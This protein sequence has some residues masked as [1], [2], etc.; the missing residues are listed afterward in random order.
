MSVLFVTALF[1]S[2]AEADIEVNTVTGRED[3]TA[4][5]AETRAELDG[6]AVLWN[7]TD[8]L[9]IFTNTA[10]NR[11]YGVKSLSNGN[12]SATFRYLGYSGSDASA[13]ENNYALYPYDANA[14]LSGE[15]ITTKINSEQIY[16]AEKVD[17]SNAL[18][19]AK[20]AST[21][22]QFVNST[23]L[24]RFYITNSMPDSYT[25]SSIKLVS[26]T[27][28]IA[29]EVTID[30]STD[31]KA[32]VT[33]N[34]VNEITLSGI[35]TP[36]T[37]QE[38]AFY[39]VIPATSFA[40]KDLTVTFTYAEGVEKSFALPAF[41]LELGSIKTIAYTINEGED[42]EG[43]TPETEL[44]PANNEIWY[45]STDGEIVKPY[46]GWYNN[47]ADALT[48][49][50]A[51]IVSNTY[52]DGKG[53][54]E[55][56]GDVT[57]IG[58]WAFDYCTS[59]TSV[60]IP[61]SVTEIGNYA[62]DYCSSLAS[63]TIPGSVTE[64]GKKAFWL[65]TS[66]TSFYGKFASVDNRC[67]IVNGELVAFAPAGLTEYTIPDSVTEI[68]DLAFYNCESL[69]SVTIP[70]S[71]TSIGEGAFHDCTS[72]TNITIPDS[73]NEIGYAAFAGCTS[74]TSVTIPDSI[75]SIGEW[76]FG[77]C[78]SL[79]SVTIPDSVT[80][81]GEFAFG[82][83]SSLTSVTIPGSVTEIGNA[84]FAGCDSLTS[85]YGKFVSV[86]NRCLIVN[87][88]LIAFAIGCGATE[89]TIPD[90]VT[91]IGESAFRYCT[92]LTSVTIPDSVNEIGYAAFES[93][94]SLKEVYCKPT[95]PPAGDYNM[96]DDNASGRKIYV[97]AESYYDYICVES[98]RDYA[99][100]IVG[101]CDIV[102]GD[103]PNNEIWYTSAN[104]SV[105]T[106]NDSSV[107]G[108]TILR[109]EYIDGKGYI[110]FDAPVT[111]IG[112]SAFYDCTSLTSVTIPDSV[113]KIG[114]YAFFNC[115]SLT[116][117]T[118]P[119]SVTEIGGS[120]F[121]GCTSLTSV[122][123]TDIAVWCQ[124]SYGVEA[125]PLDYAHNL[126]LNGE[127]V[128]D[129]VIPDS[130]TK[131]KWCAFRGCTSLRSVT[132]PDSVT[133]IGNSA[134]FSCDSL[135]SVTIPG[136][137]TEIGYSAFYDCTSLK[138]VYCK[139]TTPPDVGSDLFWDFVYG[140]KI[141][142]PTESVEAYKTAE[143]WSNY[144]SDIVGYNF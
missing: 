134:F 144:A 101:K 135:T 62:F 37:D 31:S 14:T 114:Y 98:W 45:T 85:F 132:I 73:V 63:V 50:G 61:D 141:Y 1:A 113:T 97:P 25:L 110:E 138:E 16:N 27:N 18:M 118:I 53:V 67:L 130:I 68:G 99:D 108:A 7:D 11:Q 66:L 140:R 54:I 21:S 126:Y 10:H 36:I 69:T 92:S 81:I 121:Y 90:S 6:V 112:I 102:A 39:V 19:V 79:A 94:I 96:F 20:S 120:A 84:A 89:Y 127:L 60:T 57:K 137:V 115:T 33:D 15:V 4:T 136:S 35:D 125:N 52:V 56:D 111:S 44:K 91:K 76:A 23:A 100:S 42:F 131:I 30:L 26:T 78:T 65:C 106:P 129:L 143:G 28:K 133:E 105:V 142:V 13:I 17:L 49:F 22:L 95:T 116:S 124:I 12:R 8:E 139:P 86:D 103:I 72:L 75:T 82:Y 107:F 55:F 5:I 128:T 77:Y 109:N 38:Q 74:M 3:F 2:C 123:I 47:N 83:C 70:D 71:V 43:E 80:E 32:I 9:T 59:L 122:H 29:G 88:K 64:I 87:G 51:N 48:T 93:C 40:A 119:D 117:V 58:E 24:L 46:S 34:G 41:D 104:G